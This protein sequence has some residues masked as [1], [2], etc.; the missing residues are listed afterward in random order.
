[1]KF[2]MKY[3]FSVAALLAAGFMSGCANTA[4]DGRFSWEDGWRQ[5]VVTA[6]GEG[7]IFAEKQANSCKNAKLTSQQATRYVTIM[8]R[9]VTGRIWITVPVPADVSLKPDDSVYVNVS[10]CSKRVERRSS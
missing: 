8:Y 2:K 6:V 9:P 1:M 5:G 4:N 7:P 3:G 10:D